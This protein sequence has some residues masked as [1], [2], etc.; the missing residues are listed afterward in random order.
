MPRHVACVMDGNGRWAQR[1][2][3]PRT[4]GHRAAETAVIDI[5]EAARSAGVEWLSLYAFSTEN[6]NRPGPEVDYLM[7]LVGRV[8]RKHAPLLLARG[9]R[10]RFLGAADPRVPRELAQDFADLATLT[11]GNRKMTLTVAF[12]HGGRR[13]IVEAARSL[14]RS[15]TPAEEVNEQLFAD[16][17]PLPDTPDVDLVIRTSGE[18]RISNFMLWQ[19]AYAEW[20]FPEVLWPD[21]RAP[22]FLTCLHTYRHRERRFGGVPPQTIGD[23]T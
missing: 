13:D 2:S 19:V 18:Q 1:R 4:A 11:A 23:P 5:I 16:H 9:V 12:D 3:L 6:W 17:L 14:I 15:R 21:F 22:D 20:V 7:R 8:V 10:C